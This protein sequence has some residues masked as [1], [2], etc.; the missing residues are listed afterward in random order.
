MVVVLL[1]L[2]FPAGA[3]Y[4]RYTDAKGQVHYVD[5]P[6]HIPDSQLDTMRVYRE[7]QSLD[8][9]TI[10][11]RDDRHRQAGSAAAAAVDG[12][13]EGLSPSTP[14]ALESPVIVRGNQV[15]VPV[16][17]GHL[18]RKTQ[19]NLLLDT[20]ASFTI[21]HQRAARRIMLAG[22][23]TREAVV[24]GGSRIPIQMAEADYIRIGPYRITN[25][26]IAIIQHRGPDQGYHGLL[27]MD[28]LRAL[29]YTLDV[30]RGVI[31]WNR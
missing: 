23:E 3:E 15:L 5:D 13:I 11:K 28:I 19:A 16:E 29:D 26:Q 17:I 2:V 7:D 24:V 20:G 27:G 9:Q 14:T 25:T 10:K 21:L 12:G 1:A 22:R 31:I 4:Y 18:G 8:P 30:N 6:R